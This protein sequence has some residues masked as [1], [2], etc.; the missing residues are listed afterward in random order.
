[1]WVVLY[2]RD[3]IYYSCSHLYETNPHIRGLY[4]ICV[5]QVV[6]LFVCVVIRDSYTAGRLHVDLTVVHILVGSV[7]DVV[8]F[9]CL[10]VVQLA[11]AFLVYPVFQTW[12]SLCNHCGNVLFILLYCFYVIGT[13]FG[14]VSVV[15]ML[16][17][18]PVLRVI[19]TA[20]QV[21]WCDLLQDV[22]VWFM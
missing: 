16:S 21:V 11:G 18:P 19:S 22:N 14:V 12:T 1:M 3:D 10:E 9:M 5:V 20:E 6:L 7:A 2:E 8:K 15:W 13:W 17:F 4:N